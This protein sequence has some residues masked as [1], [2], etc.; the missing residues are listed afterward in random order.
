MNGSRSVT[1]TRFLWHVFTPYSVQCSVYL[2]LG[3]STSGVYTNSH[4]P[5]NAFTPALVFPKGDNRRAGVFTTALVL[6]A[7]YFNVSAMPF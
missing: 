1:F 2:F 3:W 7:L 5:H 4:L 6:D